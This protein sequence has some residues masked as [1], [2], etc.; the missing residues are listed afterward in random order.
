[1]G[2]G[3]AYTPNGDGTGTDLP[4]FCHDVMSTFKPNQLNRV[5]IQ[6]VQQVMWEWGIPQ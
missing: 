3:D 4:G 5:E 1:M 6:D 2:L